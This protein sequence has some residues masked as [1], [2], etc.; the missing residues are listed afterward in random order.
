MRGHVVRQ[1]WEPDPSLHAPPKHRRPCSYDAFVPDSI[2]GL[3]ISI[4]GVP[5]TV[6]DLERLLEVTKLVHE[7]LPFI[8]RRKAVRKSA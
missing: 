8:K 2:A 4:L 5:P 6:D 7:Q 3:E 1:R